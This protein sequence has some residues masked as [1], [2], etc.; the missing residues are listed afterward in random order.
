MVRNALAA[1]FALLCVALATIAVAQSYPSRPPERLEATG[2]QGLAVP[3]GAPPE[4]I[5]R[6]ADA[7]QKT[8]AD[9]AV[10]E[11]FVAHGTEP[12]PSTPEAFA[13]HIRSEIEKW[14]RIARAANIKIE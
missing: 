7:L 3:A 5:G 12:T 10:R 4:V 9:P 2:C 1:G 13:R 11:K 14:T 6:L 8:M